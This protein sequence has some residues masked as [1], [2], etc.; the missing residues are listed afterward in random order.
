MA[1]EIA[2][3][4]LPDDARVR[5]PTVCA[6]TGKAASTIYQ[7]IQRGYFPRPRRLGHSRSVGWRVGDVRAWLAHPDS[8]VAPRSAD[9]SEVRHACAA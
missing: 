6:V 3:K 7:D 9:V 8:Y 4:S 2:F 5:L 1:A